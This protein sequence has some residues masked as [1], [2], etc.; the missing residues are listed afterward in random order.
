M[1]EHLARRPLKLLQLSQQ[2]VLWQV[3]ERRV[4]SIQLRRRTTRDEHVPRQRAPLTAKE[5]RHFKGYKRT[6]AVPEEGKRLVEKRCECRS[7]RLNE[8]REFRDRRLFHSGSAAGQLNCNNFHIR[9]KFLRPR[10]INQRR[11][12]GI[13]EAE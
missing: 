10:S 8:I 3:V 12:A 11:A 5:P 6:H 1:L 4:F 2:L 9:R 7:N 13:W